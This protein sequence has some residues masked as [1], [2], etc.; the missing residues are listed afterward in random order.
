MK[1]LDGP[2]VKIVMKF[3]IDSVLMKGSRNMVN[4]Y[5]CAATGHMP[6]IYRSVNKFMNICEHAILDM[7]PLIVLVNSH[8]LI[9]DRD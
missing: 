5:Q 4:N 6:G 2:C 1:F 8:L 3:L 7:M 9:V